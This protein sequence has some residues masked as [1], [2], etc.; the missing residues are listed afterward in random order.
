M[1]KTLQALIAKQPGIPLVWKIRLGRAWQQTLFATP[2]AS[3]GI[4]GMGLLCLAVEDRSMLELLAGLTNILLLVIHVSQLLTNEKTRLYSKLLNFSVTLLLLALFNNGG[5]SKRAILMQIL[6]FWWPNWF[7]SQASRKVPS[8][9]EIVPGK[10]YLGNSGAATS[11][12]LLSAHSITHIL[13]LYQGSQMNHVYKVPFHI[14]LLQM[15]Y[16]S[17]N[18]G[19]FGF[20]DRTLCSDQKSRV[21]VLVHCQQGISISPAV[22]IE[23]LVQS[24]LYANWNDAY[25]HVKKARPIVDLSPRHIPK[26]KVQ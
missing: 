16:D 7:Y 15:E 23:W 11:E 12:K 9:N 1:K 8:I 2:Y 13:E 3:I 22:V 4:V 25:E 20:I 10:L 6:A 14:R 24:K 5:N 17:T 19:A 21:R 26:T 18:A